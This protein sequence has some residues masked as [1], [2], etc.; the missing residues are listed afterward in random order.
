MLLFG[1]KA[2]VAELESLDKNCVIKEISTNL[3]VVRLVKQ[4]NIQI[5]VKTSTLELVEREVEILEYLG[6]RNGLPLILGYSRTEIYFEKLNEFG[7][8]LDLLDIRKYFGQLVS[9]LDFIHGREIAHLDISPGN[10][11]LTTMIHWF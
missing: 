4:G 1:N 9:V 2:V 7:S 8:R 6:H 11:M 5:A 10:L 3:S